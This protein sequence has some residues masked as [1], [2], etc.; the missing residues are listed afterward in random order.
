MVQ[1]LSNAEYHAMTDIYSKSMLDLFAQ[2]PTK[3]QAYLRGLKRSES[4]SMKL[5]T[6]AHTALL[7]PATLDAR[8]RIHTEG[9]S[10]NSNAYKALVAEQEAIDRIVIDKEAYDEGLAIAQAVTDKFDRIAKKIA[11]VNPFKLKGGITEASLFWTDPITNLRCRCR[12]DWMCFDKKTKSGFIID[13]KTTADLSNFSKSI[14]S[15]R[16]DVSGA[17]YSD[18]YEAVFGSKPTA[19]LLAVVESKQPHDVCIMYAPP[20]IL[21]R[22][23]KSYHRDLA[24]IR[25]SLITCE[26]ASFP[27]DFIPMELPAWAK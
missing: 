3:L 8:Y 7:E 20:E 19:Y 26:W 1:G 14:E 21:E 25:K 5:G 23:R 9:L 24:G 12:P 18:G 2:R 4:A 22:G 6:L 16:Y 10:K 11:G 17:F 15:F 27:D 13:L